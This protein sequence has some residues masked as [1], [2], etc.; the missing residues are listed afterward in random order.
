MLKSLF[1]Y[2]VEGKLPQS[3]EECVFYLPKAKIER[4]ASWAATEVM[5]K[6]AV[7]SEIVCAY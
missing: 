1:G 3:K 4:R 2:Y 7:S 5:E 6:I